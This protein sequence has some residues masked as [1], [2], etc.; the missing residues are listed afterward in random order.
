M[1]AQ[2][3]FGSRDLEPSPNVDVEISRRRET[4]IVGVQ[5]KVERS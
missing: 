1:L 5:T 2:V 3:G 4:G